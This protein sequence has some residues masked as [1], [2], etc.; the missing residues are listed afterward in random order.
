MFTTQLAYEMYAVVLKPAPIGG[1]DL[2]QQS[3]I[4]LPRYYVEL[5]CM[6][7]A[8]KIRA[9]SMRL[10]GFCNPKTN[11]QIT[12]ESATKDVVNDRSDSREQGGAAIACRGVT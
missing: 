5:A 4:D 8:F 6:S 9:R 7:C 2:I 3:V 12:A 11:L 1:V 10:Q